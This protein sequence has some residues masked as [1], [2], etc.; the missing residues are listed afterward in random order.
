MKNYDILSSI[1]SFNT[2]NDKENI[3]IMDFIKIYLEKLGFEVIDIWNKD[4]TK[5]CIVANY[6]KDINLSFVGH[7]DTVSYSDWKYDPFTLTNIDGKL[8]GLGSCDMKGGIA[9]F[10]EAIGKI[11]L[12]KLKK[13]IQIVL[14]F[15]EEI[16]FEGIKLIKKNN[17]KISDNVIV[18]EPTDL[19]P[20]VATKGCI[21]YKVICNGKNAHSSNPIVGDNAIEKAIKFIN[22]LYVFYEKLKKDENKLFDIPYTT[23]NLAKIS[24]GTAINIVPNVCEFSFD[25]RTISKKQHIKISKEINRLVKKYNVELIEITNLFPLENNEEENEFYEEI[26]NKKIACF[27]YVTEASFLNSRNIIILGPG[28]NMAHEVN[29]YILEKSYIDTVDMYI[30]IINKYCS[31]D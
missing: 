20:V 29:E 18:G 15:D 14:T 24:G 23:M 17:I 10:L 9:V 21:E 11:D 28:P 12:K 25:F 22:E 4:E 1:I 5:K 26:T 3:K 16:N 6:R 31:N 2:I 30:K 13:G 27:N 19:I 8:Y 7:T